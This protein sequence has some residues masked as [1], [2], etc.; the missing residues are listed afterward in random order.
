MKKR[1]FT[2]VITI[3]LMT[4]AL[5]FGCVVMSACNNGCSSSNS[6]YTLSYYVNGKLY[7]EENY[8]RGEKVTLI[9][10]DITEAIFVAWYS[11]EDYSEQNLV[12]GAGDTFVIKS[13]RSLY[14]R[15][16]ISVTFVTEEGATAFDPVTV[17]AGYSVSAFETSFL[18]GYIS[19]GWFYD[20]ANNMPANDDRLYKNTTLYAGYETMRDMIYQSQSLRDV[21]TEP[22]ITVKSK[23]GLT[24]ENIKEYVNAHDELGNEIDVHVKTVGDSANGMFIL[25]FYNPLIEGVSYSFERVKGTD[26][27]FVSVDETTLEPDLSK[28]TLNI[29]KE[30]VNNVKMVDFKHLNE[31]YIFEYGESTVPYINDDGEEMPKTYFK[32]A[33]Y[34]GSAFESGDVVFISESTTYTE[35]EDL[36]AKIVSTDLITGSFVGS[37][38]ES[39]TGYWYLETVEPMMEDLYSSIEIFSTGR[40]DVSQIIIDTEAVKQSIEES[41]GIENLRQEIVD[42]LPKTERIKGELDAMSEEDRMVALA[43]MQDLEF[44]AKINIRPNIDKQELYF[45]VDLSGT[46]PVNISATKRF[47]ITAGVVISNT[48][49]MDFTVDARGDK[50]VVL[51]KNGSSVK[52]ANWLYLDAKIDFTNSFT[53]NLYCSVEFKSTTGAVTEDTGGKDGVKEWISDQLTSAIESEVDNNINGVANALIGSSLID[54]S[55]LA[56]QRLYELKIAQATIPM[57]D[58][59]SIHVQFDLEVKAAAR[60]ALSIDFT[61]DYTERITIKNGKLEQR[62][63][64]TEADLYGKFELKRETLNSQVTLDITLMGGVGLRTGLKA[65]VSIG[66]A[67]VN[68]LFDLHVSCEFGP[69][70]EFYGL[71]KFSYLDDNGT[72]SVDYTGG[73][74]LEVGIYVE[75]K[76]GVNILGGDYDKTVYNQTF[77]LYKFGNEWLPLRLVGNTG[78]N[79]NN[80]KFHM[81]YGYTPLFSGFYYDQEIDMVNIKTG[82]TVRMKIWEA[83]KLGVNFNMTHEFYDWEGESA[84]VRKYIGLNQDGGFY[85]D[86]LY[87]REMRF[88]MESK[89]SVAG[90]G[91][92]FN[93]SLITYHRVDYKDGRAMPEYRITYYDYTK[94]YTYSP[95][96][97]GYYKWGDGTEIELRMSLDDYDAGNYT[98]PEVTS[99][100]PVGYRLDEENPWVEEPAYA[101]EYYDTIY[102]GVGRVPFF[103]DVYEK[104]YVPNFVPI[105]IDVDLYIDRDISIDEDFNTVVGRTEHLGTMKF[106]VKNSGSNLVVKGEYLVPTDDL[107]EMEGYDVYFKT[108][109][110]EIEMI[111]YLGEQTY[112]LRHSQALTNEDVL[113]LEKIGIEVYIKYKPKT[114]DVNIVGFGKETTQTYA[115]PNYVNGSVTRIELPEGYEIGSPYGSSETLSRYTISGYYAYD[116][117]TKKN[118]YDGD[119]DKTN[120]VDVFDLKHYFLDI[121]SEYQFW[122]SRVVELCYY[123][124]GPAPLYLR[125]N[126]YKVMYELEQ[127]VSGTAMDYDEI[128]ETVEE[129]KVAILADY[130]RMTREE[131]KT[132]VDLENTTFTHTGNKPETMPEVIDMWYYWVDINLVGNTLTCVADYSGRSEYQIAANSYYGASSSYGGEFSVLDEEEKTWTVSKTYDAK[133]L[134]AHSY[135]YIN[136]P[137]LENYADEETGKL[138]VFSHWVDENGNEPSKYYRATLLNSNSVLT[139]VFKAETLNITINLEESTIY[140]SY[141]LSY[142]LTVP[143]TLEGKTLAEVL[144]ENN[145]TPKKKQNIHNAYCDLEFVGWG[146][147]PE[148]YVIGSERDLEGNIITELTFK[149]NYERVPYTYTYT[150]ISE[151][152]PFADGTT[153]KVITGEYGRIITNEELGVVMRKEENGTT[154][155]FSLWDDGAHHFERENE[156][157]ME[158]ENRTYTAHYYSTNEYYDVTVLSTA[159]QLDDDDIGTG[160]VYFNGDINK[161]SLTFS[162]IPYGD[163]IKLYWSAN[164]N[165]I[166]VDSAKYI[167]A[168]VRMYYVSDSEEENSEVS[169]DDKIYLTI[170]YEFYL[171]ADGVT[172]CRMFTI[173]VRQ[174]MELVMEFMQ[175]EVKQYTVS[176]DSEGNVYDENGEVFTGSGSDPILPNTYMKIGKTWLNDDVDYNGETTI[177]QPYIVNEE[178]NFTFDYWIDEDNN[179]YYVGDVITVTEDLDLRAVYAYDGNI[180]VSFNASTQWGS[181]ITVGFDENTMVVGG[182]SFANGHKFKQFVGKEGGLIGINEYPTLSGATFL[183][184]STDPYDYAEETLLSAEEAATLTFTENA[185]Y[186]AVYEY[187]DANNVSV[188]LN[189]GDGSFN[190]AS[191]KTVSVRYGTLTG[192]L[193]QPTIASD[194]YVFS[195]YEDE[196]GYKVM[197]VSESATY[198]AVYAIPVYT[199]EDFMDISNN[200]SEAYVLMNKISIDSKNLSSWTPIAQGGSEGFSGMLNGNGNIVK[201]AAYVDDYRAGDNYGLFSEISGKVFD[202]TFDVSFQLRGQCSLKAVGTLA[203]KVN[204]GGV[205]RDCMFAGNVVGNVIMKNEY[206]IGSVVGVNDGLI[207]NVI[208]EC[209]GVYDFSEEIDLIAIE[210][211]KKGSLASFV[212]LNNGEVSSVV[213]YNNMTEISI[214]RGITLNLGSVVGTNNGLVQ[215]VYVDRL[216]SIDFIGAYGIFSEGSLNYGV[217][218]GENN[219]TIAQCVHNSDVSDF[220]YTVS[221]IT[222]DGRNVNAY[223]DAPGTFDDGATVMVS[224]IGADDFYYIVLDGTIE[225]NPDGL[226]VT[227]EDWING[228]SAKESL[229]DSILGRYGMIDVTNNGRELYEDS[230]LCVD[231]IQGGHY[232]STPIAEVMDFS[233]LVWNNLVLMSDNFR[234]SAWE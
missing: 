179:K 20:E 169:E 73:L 39:F 26:L 207:E 2:R 141:Y 33:Q 105:K 165:N 35:G 90:L 226:L 136:L 218:A 88:A 93:A 28:V 229:L 132:F 108:N 52:P 173:D 96:I 138:M 75:A 6:K 220:S 92:D 43:A 185:D 70:I 71:F 95:D 176:Y 8:A 126:D 177:R 78:T 87:N 124:N 130:L 83:E 7:K 89:V 147:D 223:Y 76:I 133:S 213:I 129:H 189:A 117:Q 120:D 36:L 42:A 3:L 21:S 15:S 85:V 154:M 146:V 191:S 82:E 180:V 62:N 164:W 29:A 106:V 66:V 210:S 81:R 122:A 222:I 13:D 5:L 112:F 59:I 157:A 115:Y 94:Y 111:R 53:I 143:Y 18:S 221:N 99:A 119:Y 182:A 45:M 38:G 69:Y 159:V 107:L 168:P 202:T 137:V 208:Y 11:S 228:N 103:R 172:E 14:A 139:P 84:N 40:V 65:T 47:D 175:Y 224:F 91:S 231:D 183:G 64:K 109:N 113:H 151:E 204:E 178:Y 101:K 98:I 60:V 50:E 16:T 155:Q 37:N 123:G 142:R 31:A 203:G 49:A 145:V 187:T 72:K 116:Y 217:Y 134:S 63:G 170:D 200:P 57:M 167:Y 205:V 171:A 216:Y 46:I 135:S 186:Y 1:R 194:K 56:Y 196:N 27:S 128:A 131:V 51:N 23:Q 199:L 209:G 34:A 121:P 114:V 104:G 230:C 58:I 212:G 32:V 118:I 193:P 227:K 201:I 17:D 214:N 188:T 10:P 160:T 225:S 77:P 74:Y 163:K 61:H 150:F 206:A 198:T 22:E 97:G 110:V 156:F 100:P 162:S 44:D 9:E 30:E 158:A 197:T 144:E 79:P 192:T 68:D 219:G 41:E 102:V 166:V 55:E 174:N 24:T 232:A 190:G 54:G 215:K 211:D 234:R 19:T 153:Q 25:Y 233:S 48:L 152:V 12:G 149:A 184:W 195:H 67:H 148:K 161:T 86:S 4:I 80:P 127:K 125:T 140:D 181:Y